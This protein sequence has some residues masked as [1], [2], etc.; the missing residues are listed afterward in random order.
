MAG[1]STAMQDGQA[2]PNPSTPTNDGQPDSDAMPTP[3][4][5]ARLL[6][7]F[8]EEVQEK[9]TLNHH[10]TNAE[11]GNQ[12][13]PA[14]QEYT[15]C[16]STASAHTDLQAGRGTPHEKDRLLVTSDTNF[17]RVQASIRHHLHREL[18]VEP[19]YSSGR[20]VSSDQQ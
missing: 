4:E 17:I 1:T 7:W 3:R 16:S 2:T 13:A 19:S 10:S 12:K 9:V 15:N 6:T 11:G 14:N 5:D 18:D 8:T 20:V